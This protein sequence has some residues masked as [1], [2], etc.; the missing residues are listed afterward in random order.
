VFVGGV[1]PDRGGEAEVDSVQTRILQSHMIQVPGSNRNGD[2]FELLDFEYN[3]DS[4][5]TVDDPEEWS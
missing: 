4:W 1:S 3:P 2:M 5:G